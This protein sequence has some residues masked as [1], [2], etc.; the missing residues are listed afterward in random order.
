[1]AEKDISIIIATR[2]REEILLQTLKKACL[3]IENTNTEVIVVNDGDFDLK[4]PKDILDK[5]QLY[6]NPKRG[7]T[8]ARNFGADKAKGWILFFVDDDMWINCEVIDWINNF[9]IKSKNDEAVYNINWEYPY[10]LN[11]NL[12]RSKIGRY[13]LN[14]KYHT[15]W[16]RMHQNG[17]EP[18]KG[19]YHFNSIASCSLLISKPVFK[20]IGGYNEAMIFQGEDIDLSNKLNNHSIPIYCVFDVTLHHNHQ[21]RLEINSFLKRDSDGF[22]SEFK[23]VKSGFIKPNSNISYKGMKKIMFQGFGATEKIWILFLKA[24]PNQKIFNSVNNKMIGA[25]GSLQR[26]KQWVKILG[27]N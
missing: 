16:G 12:K 9:I 5:I 26:Y 22:E 18:K 3:A 17:N 14:Y 10:P 6:N 7:V 24:I 2:N 21:D 1:M 15:M 13:I 11:D 20:K 19:L 23:A 8:S 25:L 27:K 4:L